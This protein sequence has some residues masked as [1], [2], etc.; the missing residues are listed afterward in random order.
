MFYI[1]QLAFFSIEIV[2]IKIK[3]RDV[4]RR[5]DAFAG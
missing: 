4:T 1:F 5:M 2:L 3:A